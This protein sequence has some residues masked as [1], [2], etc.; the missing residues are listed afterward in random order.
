[1]LRADPLIA[2]KLH[3]SVFQQTVHKLR[4]CFI[5]ENMLQNIFSRPH[6]IKIGKSS[7]KSDLNL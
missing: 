7:A 6:D 2:S 1:M 5:F 3:C 4:H